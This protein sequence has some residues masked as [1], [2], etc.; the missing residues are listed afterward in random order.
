MFGVDDFKASESMSKSK[1]TKALKRT[2][3]IEAA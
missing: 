2:M 1:E 3:E